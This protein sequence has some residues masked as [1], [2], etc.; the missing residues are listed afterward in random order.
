LHYILLCFYQNDDILVDIISC[1]EN[2]I[3]DAP[4]RNYLLH[5]WSID[6]NVS[7]ARTYRNKYIQA[8]RK[9]S[10]L[11]NMINILLLKYRIHIIF[12]TAF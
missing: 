1:E 4:I 12:V 3:D 5:H 2:F 7:V 9:F 6:L 8:L 10:I 11:L